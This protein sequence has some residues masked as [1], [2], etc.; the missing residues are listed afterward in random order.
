MGGLNQFQ[1]NLWHHWMVDPMGAISVG[2]ECPY[3]VCILFEITY[4]PEKQ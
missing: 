1:V 2:K 3:F 4:V